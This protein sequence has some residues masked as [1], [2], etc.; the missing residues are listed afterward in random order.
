[1]KK[2]I[3]MLL[4]L[5]M[6]FSVA[7]VSFAADIVTS[8]P[9][10]IS[11]RPVSQGISVI[12]NG[13]YV[14]FTD[15]L[16]NVVEPQLIN[17]RTMVPMRKIF[18]VFG[19]NVQW[20]GETETVTAVTEEKVLK[21]QINNPVA[22]VISG[23]SGETE[24]ITLDSVPVVVEGRTLV[25]VR[26]I[27]ESLE[28]KVGWDGETNTVVII[29]PLKILEMVEEKAPT[30]YEYMTNLT[31]WPE[32]LTSD[33]DMV[34][35]VKYTSQNNKELSTNAKFV[36]DTI[37]KGAADLY[38]MSMEC[39]LTGKGPLY[40]EIKSSGFDN[41]S[42]SMILDAK[43]MLGYVKSNLLEEQIGNKWLKIAEEAGA[44]E[45]VI[46]NPQD[47]TVENI[48]D[49]VFDNSR[50]NA[51]TYSD[52]ISAVELICKFVSD[53]FFKVSGRTTKTY[54]Y[55]IALD[56]LNELLQETGVSVDL[57]EYAKNGK[58]KFTAKYENGMYKTSAFEIVAAIKLES[59]VIDVTFEGDSTINTTKSVSIKL[60]A[61][62]DVVEY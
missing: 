43:N 48:I 59:E 12:L 33:A 52:I 41:I 2:I 6:V 36:F 34:L 13:E 31:E 53:D 15:E 61:E 27:A 17:D 40:E 51:Q 4:A 5:T 19:A 28:L 20:D 44:I 42:L 16:G 26:F 55:E 11:S 9:L 46:T 49:M 23:V 60:P 7:S 50:M 58:I 32:Q 1:M 18:E 10:L 62:K 39:N 14:D 25:P 22:E 35:N 47:Y 56:D 54:T 3:S 37:I 21:L 38:E 8:A 30:F 57:K 24:K 45:G 29:D